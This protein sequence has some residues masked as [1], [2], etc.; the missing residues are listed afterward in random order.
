MNVAAALDVSGALYAAPAPMI[1]S[2]ALNPPSDS[3]LGAGLSGGDEG[4]AGS[5]SSLKSVP[6]TAAMSIMVTRSGR[7]DAYSTATGRPTTIASRISA[8]NVVAT[9]GSSCT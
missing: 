1:F 3:L 7:G 6:P 8:G 5:V 4:V 2:A 9:S